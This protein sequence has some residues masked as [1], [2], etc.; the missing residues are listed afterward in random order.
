MNILRI[1]DKQRE[2]LTLLVGLCGMVARDQVSPPGPGISPQRDLDQQLTDGA[3][4]QGCPELPA[5]SIQVGR[6]RL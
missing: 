3:Q 5:Q 1:G 2:P 4:R 6:R